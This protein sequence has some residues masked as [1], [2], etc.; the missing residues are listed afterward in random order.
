[1][2]QASSLRKFEPK[3]FKEALLESSW[4][5]AMQEEI[6]EFER[7]DVWELNKARLVAKGYRQEEG[8]DFEESFVPVACIKAIRIFVANAANKRMTMY[9]MDVKTTFLNSELC[10]EVYVSQPK[11]F[12][13]Q[14]NPTYVHKLKKAL[15]R[16]KQAP[17][18]WYDMLSSFLMSQKLSK[19]AV[20]PTLFTRKEGKDIL[21][22]MV[23]NT[24]FDVLEHYFLEMAEVLRSFGTDN[25]GGNSFVGYPFDYRVTLGFGSIVG[26]LDPVSPVIR[27]PIERGI[28]SGTEIGAMAGVNI[29]T[30]TMEQ[31][32]ALSRENQAPGVVKPEIEGN[33]NFEIKSQF[34]RELR[35][36]TFSEN[37]NKDGHDHV[38]RVLNILSL[39]NIPGVSQDA[40]L[41]RVFPFTLTRTAKRWVDRLTSGAVNTWDLLKKAFIQSTINQQLLDSQ[42]PIPGMTPTQALMAIQTMADHSQKWHDGTLSRSLNSSSTIDGLAAIVIKLDNLGHDMKKLKENV[43]AIQV[44]CQICEGPHLDKESPLNEEVKQEEEEKYREFGRPGP[45]NRSN[46]AKYRVGPS[47]Y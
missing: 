15:Y 33:V 44:G 36:E 12:L 14:D 39:F 7:L 31:Y 13:D 30:L 19:G 27:L 20:D 18:A 34:M 1:M 2:D 35:E 3:N 8:I 47:G 37:K 38:D 28:K 46:G 17:R 45:F 16:L 29:N 10:E 41:L 26:G 42:G 43:H 22:R 32:L 4:I 9:E 23:R 11:G 6:H 24:F 25:G 21:M 40:V 5:D